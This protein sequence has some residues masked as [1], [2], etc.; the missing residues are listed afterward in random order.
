METKHSSPTDQIVWYN[1][2]SINA[3]RLFLNGFSNRKICLTYKLV[4]ARTDIVAN[5][6]KNKL[7]KSVE[8]FAS[9]K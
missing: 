3:D 4:P 9:L 8:S 2:N 6:T 1:E 5:T 7:G